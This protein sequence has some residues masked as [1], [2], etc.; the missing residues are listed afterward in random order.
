MDSV[1]ASEF[2]KALLSTMFQS[3]PEQSFHGYSVG[4]V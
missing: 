3:D 1:A 2:D 4:W